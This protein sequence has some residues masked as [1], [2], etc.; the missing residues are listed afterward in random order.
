M[1]P[2][3][4]TATATWPHETLASRWP[5]SPRSSRTP[6]TASSEDLTE[7]SPSPFIMFSASYWPLFSTSSSFS[8]T[9]VPF[10][11]PSHL[12]RVRFSSDLLGRFPSFDCLGALP[13]A[14]L[15]CVPPS[16]YLVVFTAALESFAHGANDTANATAAFSAVYGVSKDGLYRCKQVGDHCRRPR[17][18][19]TTRRPQERGS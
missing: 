13:L 2:S 9:S 16:R 4:M 14:T 1:P 17:H 11:A 3:P 15:D 18:V 8:I 19:G 5:C 7:Y 12:T 6:C 10:Y